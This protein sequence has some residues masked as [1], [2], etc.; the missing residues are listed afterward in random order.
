MIKVILFIF[1]IGSLI[2][3]ALNELYKHTNNY[4]NGLSDVLKFKKP[5]FNGVSIVVIGSNHPKY[6]FDFQDEKLSGVNLAIGPESFEYDY[7][8]LKKYVSHLAPGAVV[9][10]PVC[11]LSFFLYRFENSKTYL[12][13]YHFLNRKE[14]P[15]YTFLGKVE[16]ILPLL[17]KPKLI[18]YIIKDHKRSNSLNLEHN[19]KGTD[20]ELNNDA[21]KWI[22]GWEKQFNISLNNLVLSEK[23]KRDIEKNISIISDMIDYCISKGLKPVITLLPVTSFLLSRFTPEFIEKHILGYIADANKSGVPVMNYLTDNRFTD[24]SLYINSF[25]FNTNG[26]KK[27]TKQFVED[28]RAQSIL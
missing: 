13:Y 16:S 9:V 14:F 1:I 4:K 27:F 20:E 18:W 21:N 23:N 12:K 7:I 5:L 24:P 17:F 28:L 15:H 25:F 22:L 26:R 6:A 19:P 10:L 11:L 2:I 8:I 3:L